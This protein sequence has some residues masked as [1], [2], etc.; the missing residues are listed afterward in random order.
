MWFVKFCFLFIIMLEFSKQ[1]NNYETWRELDWRLKKTYDSHKIS[2]PVG[3]VVFVPR[4]PRLRNPA[5][6]KS[7][8]LSFSSPV[9]S[10][11]NINFFLFPQ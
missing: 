11:L 10:E 8:F 4:W 7:P 9:K 6:I 2:D 5:T 1:L 3:R